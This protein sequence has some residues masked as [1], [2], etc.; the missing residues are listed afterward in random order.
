MA[1]DKDDTGKSGSAEVLVT[2]SSEIVKVTYKG[3][4][5]VVTAG[6]IID[7]LQYV[8]AMVIPSSPELDRQSGAIENAVYN[9]YGEGPFE[10]VNQKN[11]KEDTERILK[12]GKLWVSDTKA[13]LLFL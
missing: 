7:R 4:E 8:D 11:N 12:W 2:N 9:K 10:A 13:R 5:F 6:D 3:V 1:L